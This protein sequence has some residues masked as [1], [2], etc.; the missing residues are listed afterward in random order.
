MVVHPLAV[1]DAKVSATAKVP[2]SKG[3]KLDVA[4]AHLDGWTKKEP[5]EIPI[6]GQGADGGWRV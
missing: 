2:W 3:G 6:L 4:V 5:L 1:I